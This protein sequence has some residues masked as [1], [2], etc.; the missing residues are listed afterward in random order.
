MQKSVAKRIK[1]T[2]GGKMKRRPMGVNHF[3]SR[4]N[5]KSV[6]N[7]RGDVFLNYPKK[8]ILNY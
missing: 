5:A 8:K 6:R 7:K 2:R 4:K 3:R 1:L